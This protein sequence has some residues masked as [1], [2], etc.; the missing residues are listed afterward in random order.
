MIKITFSTAIDQNVFNLIPN[1]K[2]YLMNKGMTTF[3]NG[4]V[5]RADAIEWAIKT[6][7]EVAEIPFDIV[8]KDI[9]IVDSKTKKDEMKLASILSSKHFALQEEYV[10]YFQDDMT[11]FEFCDMKGLDWVSL[12]REVRTDK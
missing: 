9:I 10:T 11:L 4:T 5:S 6:A 2:E 12:L 3:S 8:E 1:I 7:C